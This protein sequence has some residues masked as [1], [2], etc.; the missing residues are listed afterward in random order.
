M[1]S[2]WL[3]RTNLRELEYYHQFTTVD[4]FK[5]KCHDF[6]LL[7]GVWFL[8]N[9]IFDEV[10]IW[11]LKPKQPF[12]LKEIKFK[13]NGKQFIQRFVD[14][15]EECFNYNKPDVTF[16]RG[17]F[18]EYGNLTRVNPHFFG[19][20]LYCGTGRRTEPKNGG[21]Y[22]KVLVEDDRDI[23]DGN[24]PFYKTA[25]PEIFKPLWV[26]KQYDICW[27]CNFSQDSY[28]GQGFFIREV[29]KSDYLK[30]LKILHV[31][32]KPAIGK[33]ICEKYKVTNVDF[34]GHVSRDSLNSSLNLS[35]LGLVTS[36]LHDGS[37]R[38]ITEIMAAGLPL[39]LR[40]KTRALYY[41]RNS[42]FGFNDGNEDNWW[43]VE[44]TVG[45]TLGN[46]EHVKRKTV[47]GIERLSMDIICK[48]NLAQWGL[49]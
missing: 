31:G 34:A 41:Y 8:E 21:I 29:S 45:A 19:L 18:P 12:G 7:Q 35:K 44:N 24:I 20:S 13:V 25:N 23:R 49:V 14:N 39:L 3:F 38:V 36:N 48:R 2:F 17:G 43:N 33:E 6:Y 4:E 28:K 47:L 16:F 22:S 46:Y 40:D 30:K 27:P 1:K 5:Q 32:N 9:N 42:T 15:F 11:R 10:V 26:N 37:P